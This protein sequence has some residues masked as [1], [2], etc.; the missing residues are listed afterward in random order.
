MKQDIDISVI[1]PVYNSEKYIAN[2]ID[3]VLKQTI[4]PFEIIIVN[5][6]SKDN[7]IK[8]I[9]QYVQDN[10]VPEKLIKVITQDNAGAGE[11]R[12][13]GLKN[14]GGSWIAFLDSDDSWESGK[15]EKV[16][17]AIRENPMCTIIAHDE[18]SHYVGCDR[19]DLAS[20]LHLKYNPQEDLFVQLYRGNFISTTSVIVKKDLFDAIGFFDTTLQPAEDYGMWIRL[21]TVGRLCYLPDALATY[22]VRK[23]SI[24]SAIERRYEAEIRICKDNYNE[25]IRR[26]GRTVARKIARKR[27]YKIHLIESYYALKAR[28]VGLLLKIGRKILP[29]I[30][31]MK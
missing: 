31:S 25:L 20:G 26:T 15:I 21:A 7:T 23:D 17:A 4:L 2:A 30:F 24:S 22:T 6:G 8:A 28:N 5:D 29:N 9:D 14:A 11:A 12:N 27:M 3:A 19:A 16:M 13:T 18:K 1:I 10:N